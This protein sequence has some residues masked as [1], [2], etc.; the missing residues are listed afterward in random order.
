MKKFIDNPKVY[1]YVKR[2]GQ[3]HY[4]LPSG[5]GTLCGMPT[6]GS[7]Y[8]KDIWPEE[9]EE[10]KECARKSMQLMIE[11]NLLNDGDET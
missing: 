3:R 10:C 11:E 7:N 6:L 8:V 4:C 2:L 9:Q 5:K 1:I